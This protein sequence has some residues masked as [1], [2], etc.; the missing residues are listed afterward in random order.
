MQKR[1]LNERGLSLV[2]ILATLVLIGIFSIIIWR[3][4][5]QATEINSR[6]VTQNNLQQEANLIFNTLHQTHTKEV[7][8]K[9]NTNADKTQL[10]IEIKD[11]ESIVFRKTDILYEVLELT[12]LP[13]KDGNLPKTNSFFLR[14]KLLSSKHDEINFSTQ[15]KFSKLGNN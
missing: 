4:F 6:E 5:F 1:S 12:P 10:I 11:K 15:S 7:I 8:Q 14:I 9:I 3:F 13:D 2:E